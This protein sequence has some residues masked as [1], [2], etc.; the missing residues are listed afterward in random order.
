MGLGFDESLA[1]WFASLFCSWRVD[2]LLFYMCFVT[3][4]YYACRLFYS[5]AFPAL[6]LLPCW[7][8][9]YSYRFSGLIIGHNLLD[10]LP[11][12]LHLHLLRLF[13]LKLRIPEPFPPLNFLLIDQHRLGLAMIA[14]CCCIG[15]T[16]DPKPISLLYILSPLLLMF[17]PLH[18]I[19]GLVHCRVPRVLHLYSAVLYSLLLCFGALLCVLILPISN[20]VRTY[21]RRTSSCTPNIS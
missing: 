3:S 10:F 12:P 14:H 5:S 4:L 11:L 21:Q 2:S 7:L 19:A 1:H 16:L 6:W 8:F 17:P 13:L 9:L 18:W 20:S 15:D